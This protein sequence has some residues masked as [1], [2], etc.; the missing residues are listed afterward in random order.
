MA[1]LLAPYNNSMRLGQGFNSYIQ[2]I[3][4]DRAVLENTPENRK[5]LEKALRR[6]GNDPSQ[7]SGGDGGDVSALAESEVVSDP[8][9]YAE[10]GTSDESQ[11]V[12]EAESDESDPAEA[13]RK[14]VMGSK[15]KSKQRK[16][17]IK[18]P[19]WVKAQIVTYSS[20]FVDKLSDVTGE[21]L[22]ELGIISHADIV[23]RQ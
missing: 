1:Q 2:Q 8:F 5:R 20:R 18:R 16:I 14:R 4:I 9:S 6:S 13:E 15:T 19:P 12:P 21:Y 7:I 3:C 22:S 23:Q 11:D 17:E 10:T